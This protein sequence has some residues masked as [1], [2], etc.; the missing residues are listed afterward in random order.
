MY[1]K[2][3]PST[4]YSFGD[5]F[6]EKCREKEKGTKPIL[7]PSI[8]FVVVHLYTKNKLSI[9]NGCG[10]IFDEKKTVLNAWRERK[11]NNYGDLWRYL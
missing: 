1:T 8:S 4:L 6:D 3:E 7:K 11:V 10:D 5:F 2:Y 9:L